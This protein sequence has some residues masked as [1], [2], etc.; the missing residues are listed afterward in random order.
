[1][2]DTRCKVR[3]ESVK[4]YGSQDG[5]H[6]VEEIQMRAVAGTKASQG[7]PADGSDEDNTYSRFTPSA[8]FR[9]SVTNPV[10]FGQFKP[11]QKYYVDLTLAE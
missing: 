2:P 7:Y 4:F 6:T 1:M 10:L 5:S 9:I 3:V 11:E 8:D